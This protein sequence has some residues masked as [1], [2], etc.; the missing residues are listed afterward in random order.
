MNFATST[1][2]SR[3]NAIPA[4]IA[5]CSMVKGTIPNNFL[6]N[7]MAKA[8]IAIAN[9]AMTAQISGLLTVS[10]FIRMSGR[11]ML[12]YAKM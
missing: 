12:R 4:T 1:I 3:E 6:I 9:P 2:I 8:I 5:H 7:G 11:R 10:L